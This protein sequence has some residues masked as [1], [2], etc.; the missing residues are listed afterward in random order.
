MTTLPEILK[1]SNYSTHQI[2]VCGD[3]DVSRRDVRGARTH[4][5]NGKTFP[6]RLTQKFDTAFIQKWHCGMS[7]YARLPIN[8]GYDTSFGYLSVRGVQDAIS[9]LLSTAPSS[10]RIPTLVPKGAED[11]YTQIREKFVDFWRNDKPAHGENGSA[12]ATYQ[13]THEAV[14]LIQQHDPDQPMF[15]YLAFQVWR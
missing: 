3:E 5:K 8:R 13:Y 12:Y 9:P 14:R 15:M 2:G 1:R 11:H 10:L 6:C 7:S 4:E